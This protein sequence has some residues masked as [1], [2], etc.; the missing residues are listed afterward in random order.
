MNAIKYLM[1]LSTMGAVVF[2]LAACGGDDN[3]DIPNP[4]PT[5]TIAPTPTATPTPAPIIARYEVTLYNTTHN[6]PLSPIAVVLHDDSFSAW[7]IG[8]PASAGLEELAESGSPT[9]FLGAVSSAVDSAAGD[10]PTGPGGILLLEVSGP[11][12]SDL[13][14]TVASMLV[15][16]NDGFAGTAGWNIGQLEVGDKAKFLAPVYDAGTETNSEMEATIPGP[17]AGGEGY[18][19]ERETRNIITRHPGVVTQADGYVESA[20]N[21]SHRFDNGA[22]LINVERVL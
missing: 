2:T 5:P 13:Q 12:A 19:A 7:Q 8:S 10:N 17:A 1:H 11:W 6:Q 18:N 15:N 9:Q 4:T 21:E 3:D 22:M 20:L 16:T 14:L